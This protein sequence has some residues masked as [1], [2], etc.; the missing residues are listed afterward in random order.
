MTDA[1]WIEVAAAVDEAVRHF[2]NATLLYDEGGF[3]GGGIAGYRAEMALM[4]AMQSAHTALEGALIRILAILG[5]EAPSGS[6]SH[7]DLI[8]RVS[9]AV[10]L[11]GLE[12]PAILDE[13]IAAD[14]HETRRFGHK[15]VHGYDSFDASKAVPSIEAARR[16]AV[17]LKTAIDAFK[18]EIDP[19]PRPSSDET[20]L[21]GKGR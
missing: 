5:E 3:D 12:R 20:S 11:P 18:E 7:E 2:T 10:S 14:L 21:F 13:Q 9:K 19:P 16:L 6:S 1:R 8:V 15:A 17:K 4:H